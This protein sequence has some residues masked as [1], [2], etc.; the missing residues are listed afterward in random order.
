V[1]STRQ[2][3]LYLAIVVDLFSRRI[4]GTAFAGKAE[5]GLVVR[6]FEAA[7]HDRPKGPSQMFHSDQGSQYSSLAFISCLRGYGVIQSMSRKATC[8]DNAVAEPHRSINAETPHPNLRMAQ[9]M[10]A[11]GN[12]W[13]TTSLGVVLLTGLSTDSE[14]G[15]RKSVSGP[16]T[17]GTW[18]K[19]FKA[20]RFDP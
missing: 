5:A 10:R 19:S 20:M 12:W 15:Y 14:P 2:G 1:T 3:W 17:P 18:E 4:V 9:G 11:I 6:A 7:M 16:S 8:H 13:I